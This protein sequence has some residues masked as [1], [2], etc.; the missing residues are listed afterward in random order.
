LPSTKNILRE[1]IDI[2]V[3]ADVSFWM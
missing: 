1:V 2:D 3:G